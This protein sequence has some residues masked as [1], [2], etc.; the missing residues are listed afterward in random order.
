M[1]LA[2]LKPSQL[3]KSLI[4]RPFRDEK[5]TIIVVPPF[6]KTLADVATNLGINL[7]ACYAVI[8]DPS[9]RRML[10]ATYKGRQYYFKA[11]SQ[12]QTDDRLRVL[13]NPPK[14]VG[15]SMYLLFDGTFISMLMPRVLEIYSPM[16][17]LPIFFGFLKELYQR[18][19]KYGKVSVIMVVDENATGMYRILRR[20][21]MLKPDREPELFQFFD[22]IRTINIKAILKKIKRLFL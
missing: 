19:S 15:K 11:K 9:M 13:L 18:A 7:D 5:Q 17:A 12:L 2:T 1:L 21:H 22:K 4:V 8:V 20:L 6:G 14:T 3:P 10:G 16:K